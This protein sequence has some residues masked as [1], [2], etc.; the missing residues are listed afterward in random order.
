[1]KVLLPLMRAAYALRSTQLSATMTGE[2]FDDF[3]VGTTTTT[4]TTGL[5]RQLPPLSEGSRRVVLVRHAETDWNARGLLQ[6][7]SFDVQLNDAGRQQAARLA[8][9]L[10]AAVPRLDVVVSSHLHRASETADIVQ[11]AFGNRGDSTSIRIIN[12]KFAE[13][14]F[15]DLEGTVIRGPDCTDETR[16]KF[17]D[18]NAVMHAN[19]SLPWPGSGESIN[20]VEQRATAGLNQILRGFPDAQHIGIVGHGRFNKVLLMSLL[21]LQGKDSIQQGNTGINVLDVDQD[22]NWKAHAINYL[23]HTKTTA[24]TKRANKKE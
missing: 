1:M 11:Q 9:E 6:G 8:A 12:H 14:K 10:T 4:T 17:Q 21:G 5:A 22:G 7:G 24:T 13:M 15:G 3:G 19:K 2:Y 20:D 16:R 23:A 18:W